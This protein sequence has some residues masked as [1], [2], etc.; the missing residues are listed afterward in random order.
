M[1]KQQGQLY[2]CPAVNK[3]ISM[4][5]TI[6]VLL[7]PVMSFAQQ[8]ISNPYFDQPLPG[9]EPALFAPAVISDELGNRDMAISPSGDEIFYTT[10]YRG[11]VFSTIMYT[12]KVNGKWTE[13]EIASF[14]SRYNDMEPAFSPDGSKL[15]FASSRPVSGDEQK[16][17]DIWY[18]SKVKGV[19]TDPKNMGAP[20]NTARDEFYPSV[21]KTG[22][23]YF[24]REMAGKG[25]DIV[26]C[27]LNADSY[28]TAVSLPATVNSVGA[29]FNAFVDPDEQYIMFTGYKRKGNAGSGDIFI[30]KKNGVGEWT[31]AVNLGNKINGPGLTYC[32]YVTPDK[33]YFFFSS[34][35]GIFKTP[36]PEKQSLKK[37]KALINSPLN[38]WDNIYWVSVD[39]VIF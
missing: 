29:E 36:F 39:Q 27:K 19:W 10:Q 20:V 25:E 17:Y 31:E 5:K 13:P 7:I 23:I 33:K 35:R 24:T 32:P 15:Y 22:N 6:I 4:K 21:A 3:S 18:V 26:V 11:G 16:D 12:K 28:D 2:A 14:C 1:H 9:K 34:S 37:L 8:K 38:G 30:S